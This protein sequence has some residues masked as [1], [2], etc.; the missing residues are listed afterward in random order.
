MTKT[1]K[2]LERYFKGLSNHRRI[3]ILFL[4]SNDNNLNVE[5]ISKNLG[6]NMK[7]VA[8][9]TQKLFAAGL[10]NKKYRGREVIHSLSP[11]GKKCLG[12]IKSFE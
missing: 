3:E 5:M 6:A 2:Q 11:Y 7:T 4:I 10:V 12:F 8:V 9:H 1:P